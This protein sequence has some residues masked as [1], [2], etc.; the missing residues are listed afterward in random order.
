[1]GQRI[2]ALGGNSGPEDVVLATVEE[3]HPGTGT[4]TTVAP[5][6]LARQNPGA[7]VV[8][9]QIYVFG[10]YDSAGEITARVEVFDPVANRWAWV[11][12]LP[13]PLGGPGVAAHDGRIFIVGGEGPQGIG[14]ALHIYDPSSDSYGSGRPAPTERQLLKAIERAGQIYT[15]GG[16]QGPGTPFLATV[17]RYHPGSDTWTAVASMNTG[18]GNPGVAIVQDKIVVVGGA[19]RPAGA[20]VPLTTA[21]EYDSDADRWDPLAAQL[22]VGLASLCAERAEGNRVIAIGG[23]QAGGV[24]SLRVEALKL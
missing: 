12:D 10:G 3:R 6:Q 19:S 21:E 15:V 1:V 2:F 16:S 23:F 7:A 24:A 14:G 17:E 9:G 20:F 4:W 18:R 22:P 5:M 11:R 13:T 8:G